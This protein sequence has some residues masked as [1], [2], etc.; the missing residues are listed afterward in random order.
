MDIRV[1]QPTQTPK[2]QKSQMKSNGKKKKKINALQIDP[3]P[4][5]T[6]WQPSLS[7]Q[8]AAF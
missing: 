6:T 7:H 8:T 1:T 2:A 5:H 3:Y 4:T